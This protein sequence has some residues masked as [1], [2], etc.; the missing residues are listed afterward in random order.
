MVNLTRDM[1]SLDVMQESLECG[2]IA[3]TAPDSVDAFPF[4]NK[5]PFIINELPHVFFAGNQKQL[6]HRM[7]H[8]GNDGAKVLLLALPKFL[9]S[10][11]VALL[12][13]R[14]MEVTEYNFSPS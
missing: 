11:S 8:I 5:D 9:E 1:S 4:R 3:P 7:A 10:Y 6:D 14:T 13:I 12:N 2:L